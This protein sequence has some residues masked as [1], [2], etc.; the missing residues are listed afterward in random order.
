MQQKCFAE[1]NLKY[2]RKQYF[3]GRRILIKTHPFILAFI[4]SLIIKGKYSLMIKKKHWEMNNINW[5][6]FLLLVQNHRHLTLLNESRKTQNLKTHTHT[7]LP[8]QQAPT[9]QKRNVEFPM[10]LNNKIV[11][12]FMNSCLDKT[13]CNKIIRD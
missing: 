5:G 9:K 4:H 7:I 11:I 2:N 3:S 8:N 1:K 13:E 10:K 12:Y 6:E